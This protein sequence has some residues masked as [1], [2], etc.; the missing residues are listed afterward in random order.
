M[1]YLLHRWRDLWI[2]RNDDP[3]LGKAGPFSSAK[4]AREWVKQNGGTVYRCKHLDC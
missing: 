1:K 2:L 3:E 4:N